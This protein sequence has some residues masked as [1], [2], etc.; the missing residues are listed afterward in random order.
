VYD[1]KMPG[2]WNWKNT[3]RFNQSTYK[4]LKYFVI[5]Y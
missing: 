3:L 5:A 4:R 2:N 1:E